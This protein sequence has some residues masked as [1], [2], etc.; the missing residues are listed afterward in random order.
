MQPR[1][2]LI[3][4]EDQ[5]ATLDLA[6]EAARDGRGGLVLVTGEAGVGKTA[7]VNAVLRESGLTPLVSAPSSAS[8]EPYGPIVALFRT[9]LREVPHGLDG[10]QPLAAHLA[11]LLPELGA[12]P[13]R[14][15]QPTLYE[16]VRWGFARIA[17]HRPT[18]A[19][20]HDLHWADEARWPATCCC[21]WDT[22][23]SPT[24]TAASRAGRR[25]ATRPRG[26][27]DVR[28]HDW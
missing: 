20:V 22:R 2:P 13:E 10:P 7:L 1:E 14:S 4:R 11:I 18:L 8:P 16:A 12:P 17:A 25:P 26:P 28:D 27:R 9:F 19:F 15:D 5:R 23:T 21:G 6:I 24:W 3:G